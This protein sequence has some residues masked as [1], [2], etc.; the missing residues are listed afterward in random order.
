MGKSKHDQIAEYLAK[1]FGTEYK[2]QKEIDIVTDDR[3]RAGRIRKV[4]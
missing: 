4:R 3:K 2:K 1:K